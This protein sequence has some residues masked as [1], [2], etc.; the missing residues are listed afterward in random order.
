MATLLVQ[1]A[2]GDY[3]AWRKVYDEVDD[4][5]TQ[6]GC[7]AERVW[8]APGSPNNVLVLHEFP[9]VAAAEGFASDPALREAMD[10]AGVAGPP[11]IEIWEGVDG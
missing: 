7:T 9:T 6:H 1:H 2:V 8:Q 5:R 11:R 4:L 10:R 3:E